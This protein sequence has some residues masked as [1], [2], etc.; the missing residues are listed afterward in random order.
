MS[1]T[2]LWRTTSR[3][4]RCT[5]AMSSIPPSTGSSPT[6]PERP[7]GHV[8][9]G[10]VA[11]DDALGA[12]AD[13]GEEHLHLLGRRVLRLVE[14][15]E[16]A[17]ERAAAHEGERRHLD[18]AAVE[19][20]LRALGL[21]Q[22]VE[23]V[24]ERAQVRVDL[25]HQ[26][27]GQEAEPLPRLDGRAGEDDPRH[28]ARLQRVHGLG[29]GQVRLAGPGRADAEG[30][31]VLRDGVDVALLPGRVGAHRLAAG[32]AHHLGAQ[33]LAR[34]DV[35]AHHVDGA[36]QGRGV[37]VLARLH[38]EDQ[39]L[40]EPDHHLGR[41]APRPRCGCPGRRSA[42]RGRPPRS[43]AGARRGSRAARPSGGC[44]GRSTRRAGSVVMRRSCLDEVALQRLA[45]EHVEVQVRHRVHGVGPDVEDEPVAPLGRG[46][47]GCVGHGPG[48]HAACRPAPA[49]PRRS[50]PRRRRCGA[51]APP[52]RAAGPPG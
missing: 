36:G 25:G 14:D 33:H 10:D 1:A 32:G 2:I 9:L 24:V 18:R 49:R 44:R 39:L 46:Q 8:D 37:E 13:A 22:V 12:E 15:D 4:V 34:A 6:R 38:H 5:N 43:G 47:A 48:R 17:V 45:P 19:Q 50:R 51:A 40:E 27:A 20:A 23:R 11:G 28:L 30:D 42:R 52:A 7:P 26:V 16:R 41:R 35:L 31:D 29:D 21:E 3:R